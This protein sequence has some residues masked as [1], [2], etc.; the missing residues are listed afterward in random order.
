MRNLDPASRQAVQ[1]VIDRHRPALAALPGFVDA[2]PGFP[3]VDGQ[4][5]RE[6]AILVF[7]DHKR[8]PD[9]VL[10]EDRA[11][12]QLDGLRV[13]VMQA[14][15][16]RQLA[17]QQVFA[18]QAAQA[19]DAADAGLRYQGIAGDPIDRL[20][21][22][23]TPILCHVGPDAGWPAL[24]S[25]LEGA[26][27]SLT[28]AM[29]DFNAD[30]VANTFIDTVRHQQL[31]ARLTWDDSMTAPET[32]I[33]QRLKDKLGPLL[34]GAIVRC[35][36]QRRF[37]SAYHEKVAV[38]DSASFWLSS[39]NWSRRSQPNIDPVGVPGDAAG[40][41]S[42]GNREWHVIVADAPL[43]RLFERYIEH[44]LQGS[45]DELA[46]GAP[47]AA[48]DRAEPQ[49]LP[50]LFI[51]MEALMESMAA[52][53]PPRPVAPALLPSTPR[54]FQVMPLLTPDNYLK[55]I[56]QLIDAATSALYLQFSYINYSDKKRDAD[57][58]RMLQRLGER[59]WEPQLDMRIIVGSNDASDKIRLLA[60]AGFNDRVFRKQGGI[61]NK[62][63]IVDHRFVLVSSTNWSAD[64]VLRNR[65]AGLLI[66]EP[67]IAGYYERVF[68]DDW[69]RRANTRFGDDAPVRLARDGEPTP[70][71]MVRIG[72]RDYFDG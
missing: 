72:W 36:A 66:D 22:V 9:S 24:R 52:A 46:A 10:P 4:L 51:P 43:A 23:S 69:N 61:H 44:D 17:T 16:L 35:G 50:D 2:E 5:L 54:S 32:E 15:P 6:P 21:A 8:P 64:G 37:A 11:P 47:G 13:A 7:V 48:L 58:T 20:H 29:Y 62:G 59:S 56:V 57:F 26:E 40:M 14:D 71:G 38:R 25:F 42:K 70:A 31:A 34:D 28:V 12:R 53:A 67:E 18:A 60:Q 68:L 33:R 19:L 39:G 45:K 63:I 49:R 30:H 27:T 1:D 41:Y 3:I 55:H 65:D